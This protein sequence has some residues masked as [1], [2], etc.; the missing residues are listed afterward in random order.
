MAK[1][2]IPTLSLKHFHVDSLHGVLVAE[3]SELPERGMSLYQL[4]DDACDVGIAVESHHTGKVQLYVLSEEQ[5]QAGELVAWKFVPYPSQSTR[6]TV[7]VFN[8]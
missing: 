5:K 2:K 1:M 6:F 7:T 3:A 4:F 8:D